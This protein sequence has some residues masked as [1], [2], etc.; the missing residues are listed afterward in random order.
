[1]YAKKTVKS[2]ALSRQTILN[3]VLAAAVF[4]AW[5]ISVIPVRA[6]GRQI[7]IIGDSRT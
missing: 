7:V 3:I 5:A 2:A 4:L 1:M 6:E